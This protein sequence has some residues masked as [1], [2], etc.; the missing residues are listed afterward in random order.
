[1]RTVLQI[2]YGAGL[3][4]GASI[5]LG[6]LIL[7]NLRGQLRRTE[8]AVFAFL[9]G[10]AAMNLLIFLLGTVHLVRRGVLQ[11]LAAAL[12]AAAIWDY[13]KRG[14]AE[15]LPPMPLLWSGL[16]VVVMAVFGFQYFFH[17]LAPEISPDGTAYHLEVVGAYAR[18]NGLI[19]IPTNMYAS[20]SQGIE[21]LFLFAYV[22]GRN[23][24]AAM[25]H[26]A[27]LM[28]L[29]L[30][31]VCYGRRFGHPGAGAF[32]AIAVFA[33]PLAGI[34]GISAY[35]DIALAAAAF[36]VF[37]LFRIWE[38]NRDNRILALAGL[39]A[40]YCY[41]LKYTGAFVI[42][43][44]VALAAWRAG[45]E[46]W[47]ASLVAGLP[48]SIMVAP[49]LL[50]NWL[51]A[52]NPLA[53][54]F[55]RWFPNPFTTVSFELDYRANLA[56]MQDGSSRWAGLW[57]A[58]VSGHQSQGA[59]GPLFIL[60]PV[61]LLA[62]RSSEGRKL[63]AFALVLLPGYVS[64]FGARFLLPLLPFVSLGMGMALKRPTV[65]LP[66]L[67]AAHAIISMPAMLPKYLH[68]YAWRLDTPPFAAALRRIPEEEFL[69]SRVPAYPAA[70]KLD[71]M[72]PGVQMI[73][74]VSGVPQAYTR[75]T[76]LIFY[77]SA[78]GHQL[79]E[80]LMTARERAEEVLLNYRYSFAPRSLRKIRVLQTGPRAPGEWS[81]AE[82][83]V[84]RNGEEL[85]RSPR[86]RLDARPNPWEV[87][88]AFDNNLVTRWFSREPVRPGM[89]VEIDFGGT[90]TVDAVTL[91]AGLWQ[92]VTLRVEGIAETGSWVELAR[93]AQESHVQP[94]RGRRRA[95]MAEFKARGVHYLIAHDNEEIAEDL[96]RN[97]AYWG[98][99][100]VFEIGA[101]RLYRID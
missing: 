2:L 85:P 81:M 10:S 91:E 9:C 88:S 100:E 60:A 38:D 67:A 42:P 31:L 82:M 64:N 32:A 20:L 5:A 93:H 73:Y 4:V 68:P 84:W 92:P 50:K 96:Q 19:P 36:G 13:R 52:G 86:W 57:D 41:A 55:N 83:R 71:E 17:A 12:I 15:R 90:E 45:R 33:C 62:L 98:I 70:R 7:R 54:F 25:V 35:N 21:M 87:Q 47:K 43:L 66:L 14:G 78:L 48:A 23:S 95:A 89:W 99:T 46:W 79:R 77:Q 53:P 1:M 63:L 27:F 76:I 97:A 6:V 49:W 80:F 101:M 18:A 61:A 8:Y 34:D 51:W 72:I 69:A 74:A 59:I 26:F 22:F 37:Y 3:A 65:V 30:L 16:L 44:L 28:A 40:G 39:L 24:A 58:L 56:V 29:P 75:H 94:Q 11:T